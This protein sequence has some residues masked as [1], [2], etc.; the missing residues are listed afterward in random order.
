MKISSL[1]GT[2]I[3]ASCLALL[4]C[5]KS[6]PETTN[7][8]PAPAP[9]P[10]TD[11]VEVAAQGPAPEEAKPEEVAKADPSAEEAP[12]ERKFDPSAVTI[13]TFSLDF[14]FDDIDDRSE[15]ANS[16]NAATEEDWAWKRDTL[17]KAIKEADL[18]ILAVQSIGGE[19]EAIELASA[20]GEIDGP[21]Y[22]LAFIES[23]D[24]FTGQQVALFS[25][26]AV[27]ETKRFELA[28]SKQMVAEVAFPN[29][30]HLNVVVVQLRPGKY[31][32]Q[33]KARATE[34]KAIKR[35]VG[36]LKGPSVILGGT[37]AMYL[38][39][40]EGYKESAAG[41]LAGAPTR[42]KDDDCSDSGFSARKTH[43]SGKAL[44]RIFTCGVV[45]EGATTHGQGILWRGE[46][47]PT[48]GSWSDV[49][50]DKAPMRDGSSHLIVGGT[51]ALPPMPEAPAE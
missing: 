28:V 25:R 22:E 10:A 20:I 9:A 42:S 18:D 43:R 31:S 27:V 36:R 26:Y 40:E 38:P 46:A 44:D 6:S 19:R 39:D 48:K 11:K 51:I 15:L 4:A 23:T 49:P 37:Y 14:A 35:S 7:P 41:H 33:Q 24:S 34:A 50:V 16:Q 17:A 29:D 47:D 32:A 12:A 45:L 1:L 13:G 8:E 30:Q 3:A 2:S 21:A 5:E